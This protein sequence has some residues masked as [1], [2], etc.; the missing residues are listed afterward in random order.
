[1]SDQGMHVKKEDVSNGLKL[2]SAVNVVAFLTVVALNARAGTGA[3]AGESIGEIANEYPSYFLP[4][5]FTFAIWSVIYAG[6]A[7]FTVFQAT[8]W[9][10]RSDAVRSVGGAWLLSCLLN[11]GWVVSFSYRRL[12]ASLALM[13]ALLTVLFILHRRVHHPPYDASLVE[14]VLVIQPFGLYLAWISVAII[15]N[16]FH[17]LAYRDWIGLTET[18]AALATVMMLGAALLGAWMLVRRRVWLFPL[19]V[20]WALFGIGRRWPDP[21]LLHRAAYGLSALS[22]LVLLAWIAGGTRRSAPSGRV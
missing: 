18:G 4:A 19:V 5:D 11:V 3:L 12:G 22:I 13:A 15:A 6:L 14:N 9:G 2:W 7:G 1:M 20:A 17:F 16:T 21:S 8:P 10:L